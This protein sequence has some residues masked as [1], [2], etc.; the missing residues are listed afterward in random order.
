MSFPAQI[1]VIF[2]SDEAFVC[3]LN[4]DESFVCSMGESFIPEIYHGSTDITPSGSVQ[5]LET[6]GKVIDGDITI[7]P[8]PSNYGLITWDGSTITVS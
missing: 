6:S 4:E 1:D 5:I 7:E 3:G 2:N 8:I